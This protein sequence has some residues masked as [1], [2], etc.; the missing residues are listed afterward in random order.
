MDHQIKAAIVTGAAR[1]LGRHIALSLASRGMNVIIH[2]NRSK[3]SAEE[4]AHHIAGK[5]V[6][7]WPVQADFRHPEELAAFGEKCGEAAGEISVLVNS[8]S[9]FNHG[10][11]LESAESDFIENLKINALAPLALCRWFAKQCSDGSIVHMLDARMDDYDKDHI[12][13]A[14]SKQA[15]KSITRI[16]SLELAPGIRVNG[17][18]PGLIL[19]PEGK[20]TE[21]LK[22]WAAVNP[23]QT[24]G[25][26][27][28]V[29]NAVLY[30]IDAQF[31]T[32]QVIYLDGG[33]HLK[34]V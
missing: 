17:V 34:G 11:I 32:G 1:R 8:A 15:L 20:G 9:I 30:L 18:A 26:E 27:E 24:W 25:S 10:T 13:Y 21:Y 2:Y 28:D 22:K 31:V 5:G 7:A 6:K 33:R 29:S 19:P 3:E 4:T 14:L 12:P 23:L 16:L